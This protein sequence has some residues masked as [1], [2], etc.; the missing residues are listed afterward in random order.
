MIENIETIEE[1]CCIISSLLMNS[2]TTNGQ[3]WSARE[4]HDVAINLEV[5]QLI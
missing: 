2:D 5:F 1:I 3:V 4:S